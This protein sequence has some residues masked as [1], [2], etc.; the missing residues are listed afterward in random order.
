M[1]EREKFSF[2]QGR[3]QKETLMYEDFFV[4][5]NDYSKCE[6][7]TYNLGETKLSQGRFANISN[8]E[9]M[10]WTCESARTVQNQKRV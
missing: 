6:L 1:T 3:I 9:N 8:F 2:M 4:P 10:P 7:H 5:R